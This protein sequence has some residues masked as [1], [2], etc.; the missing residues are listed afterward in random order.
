MKKLSTIINRISLYLYVIIIFVCC[1]VD[2]DSIENKVFRYNEYR[3][4]TSLDPAFSRNRK[5]FG[6]LTKFLMALFN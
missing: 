5:I 1:T 2:K 4:V 3:N 6:Q